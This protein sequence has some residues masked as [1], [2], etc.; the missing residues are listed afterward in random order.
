MY[1]RVAN[2]NALFAVSYFMRFIDCYTNDKYIQVFNR[3]NT[4][5]SSASELLRAVPKPQEQ[6]GNWMEKFNEDPKF[7]TLFFLIFLKF[8]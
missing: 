3:L 6:R 1:S 4:N 7:S 5:Y 2:R 8:Y